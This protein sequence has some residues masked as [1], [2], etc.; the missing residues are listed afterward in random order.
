MGA[1]GTILAGG[2]YDGLIETMGGPKTPG[3]GWAAG[4]DRLMDLVPKEN[5]P[6]AGVRVAFV[7]ADEVGEISAL[8]LSR[9]LRHLGII[10]EI[11]WGGNM[12]KKMKKAAA[13]GALYA[14]IIGESEV[15]TQT[16]ML[17]NLKTGEQKSLPQGDL[18]SIFA[19]S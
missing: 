2:R 11:P 15:Q 17:K 10:C 19:Q 18:V 12:G 9:S 1:Q 7:A 5:I 13:C 16:V 3:V 14:I 8:Q 6:D 4:I